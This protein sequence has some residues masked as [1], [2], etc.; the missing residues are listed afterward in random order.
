MPVVESGVQT[1][2]KNQFGIEAPIN[3]SIIRLKKKIS[4]VPQISVGK[5]G[6]LS[7]EMLNQEVI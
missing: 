6:T 2:L 5:A 1:T 7:N 3:I 4:L